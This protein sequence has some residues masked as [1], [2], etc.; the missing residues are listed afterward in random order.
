[1]SEKHT[2]EPWVRRYCDRV[3]IEGDTDGSKSIAHCYST[4][5]HNCDANAARIVACVNAC[6]GIPTAKLSDLADEV[7]RLREALEFIENYAKNIR[8]GATFSDSMRAMIRHTAQAAL[9]GGGK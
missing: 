6:Q 3:T 5:G 4:S 2:K 1:M 9:S 8:H 7:R